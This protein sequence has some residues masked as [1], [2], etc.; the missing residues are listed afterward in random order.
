MFMVND[1]ILN[2][3][4]YDFFGDESSKPS[5]SISEK[6]FDISVDEDGKK[7][8]IRGFID[9]LFLYKK[10]GKALIRDFKTSKS[11]FKGKDLT[12]NL[13]DLMYSL[14][15]KKIYPKFISRSS[16]FLF[17]KFDLEKDLLGKKGEGVINMQEISDDELEGF[18]YFLTEIQ[19]I[20]DGF[21]ENQAKSNLAGSQDFPKDGSFSGPLSCGFAK[22]PNQLKKDG[23]KMWHCPH[24]FEY[25]YFALK[26]KEGK[27]IKTA[28]NENQ[29]EASE[30]YEIV[31]LKYD[32]CPHWKK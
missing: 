31:E 20:I 32:G 11:V 27:V 21:D 18:E 22:F 15:V 13:Q 7:Y 9:K 3:L 24:K 1:M 17:L 12:D 25:K 4:N 30:D 23:T 29:L 8:K 14:A 19:S 26:D 16:E 5:E 2:G 10:S 28:F 6:S